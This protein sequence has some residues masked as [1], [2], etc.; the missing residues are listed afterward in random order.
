MSA[1]A[2]F[3]IAIVGFSLAGIALAISIALFVKLNIPAVIGDLSG[4][5]VAREIKAMRARNLSS[6]DKSRRSSR[7]NVDNGRSTEKV[8]VSPNTADEIAKAKAK[9]HSSKRLDKTD[10]GL[11][12]KTDGLERKKKS[13][14]TLSEDVAEVDVERLT[15]V[16]YEERFTDVL[17]ESRATD[18]LY[19]TRQTEVLSETKQTEVL[20]E[21]KPTEIL[22]KARQTDVLSDEE[23]TTSNTY[24][25]VLDD[26]E[27]DEVQLSSPVSFRITKSIVEIHTDEV[28]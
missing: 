27:T 1:T 25:T 12:E 16:L 10:S 20:S 19:E 28:I 3:I 7:G 17:I 6:N 15:D 9:A 21:S 13:T 24:T 23:D 5:T 22:S 26:N 4:K 2:W 18:V 8:D 14:S 11:N